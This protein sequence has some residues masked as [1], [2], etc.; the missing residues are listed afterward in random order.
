MNA[1]ETS[2]IMFNESSAGHLVLNAE[3][4]LHYKDGWTENNS[5]TGKWPEV[6]D[7]SLSEEINWPQ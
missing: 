7:K 4:I 2:I 6:K 5:W 3:L 1:V